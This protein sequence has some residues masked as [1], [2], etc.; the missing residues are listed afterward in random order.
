MAPIDYKK[1]LHAAILLIRRMKRDYAYHFFEPRLVQDFLRNIIFLPSQ[2]QV[3]FR[4]CDPVHDTLPSHD[5]LDSGVYEY[6][7]GY[8]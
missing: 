2:Y 3:L 6:L 4:C 8:G 7:A 1:L 5:S